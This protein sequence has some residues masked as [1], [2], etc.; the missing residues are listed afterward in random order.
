MSLQPNPLDV[1]RK[2]ANELIRLGRLV[3]E[4]L[5][6]E[7]WIKIGFPLLNKMVHGII[8]CY[9]DGE[10]VPGMSSDEEDF[11]RGYAQ[12]L[13]DY[14]NRLYSYVKHIKLAKSTLEAME[15]AEKE[16]YTIPM[17]NEGGS[18]GV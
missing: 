15:S 9:R 7:G 6:T 10:W 16:T 11:K 12:A 4:M 1:K 17:I 14:H 5:A 13:M 2:K 8:G 3:K 18:Y